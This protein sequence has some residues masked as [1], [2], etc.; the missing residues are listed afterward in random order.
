[1]NILIT[2]ATSGIGKEV[3]KL[4]IRD[5]YT[6]GLAGRRIELLEELRLMQPDKVY[7]KAIDIND[8][9]ADKALLELIEIM[10]GMD[11]YFHVS[12]VGSVNVPL[13]KNIELRTVETNCEGFTR[14]LDAA[15]NYFAKKGHGHI[16]AI[17]SIAGTKGLGA[18]PAYS[19][20]KRY[21]RSYIQALVQL[22]RLRGAAIRFTEIRPGF[23]KT[24]LLK[25]DK[26]PLLMKKEKVAA[27]I[28][29]SILQHK[30]VK[31]IDWRYRI[32]VFFWQ[33]APNWLWE[34]LKINKKA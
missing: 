13:D 20:T 22:A 17:S 6:V 26:Y 7:V 27:T 24:D 31:T 16:A 12:G 9:N 29:N 21:Q 1:M 33:I 15:F 32:I 3:A 25:G 18:A 8:D 19:A 11:I 28:Y 5:G 10:G 14:M 4:F 34:R 23:V 2:G 30:R